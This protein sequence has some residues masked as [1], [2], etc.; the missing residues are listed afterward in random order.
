MGLKEESTYKMRAML[1]KL[2]R[3]SGNDSILQRNFIQE[4]R[5]RVAAQYRQFTKELQMM[6]R[7]RGKKEFV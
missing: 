1:P 3:M 4:T 7:N 5:C 2:E 6:S